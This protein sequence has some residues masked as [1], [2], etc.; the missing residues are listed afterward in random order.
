MLLMMITMINS[1]EDASGFYFGGGPTTVGDHVGIPGVVLFFCMFDAS[2][3]IRQRHK[4]F[5]KVHRSSALYERLVL[6]LIIPYVSSFNFNRNEKSNCIVATI[7]NSLGRLRLVV[8]RVR[9]V[10]FLL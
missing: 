4:L 3:S 1:A 6:L 10:Y 5:V 9:V 2:P 7:R 8:S